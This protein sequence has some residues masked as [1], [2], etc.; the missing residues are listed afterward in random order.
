[1]KISKTMRQF[2]DYI[3]K[4]SNDPEVELF[5]MEVQV[6]TG[7]VDFK[8]QDIQAQWELWREAQLVLFSQVEI[9][10]LLKCLLQSTG[11]NDKHY[12]ELI[13]KVESLKY[14]EL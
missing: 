8:R 2:I 6:S 12:C 11:E 1:M 7:Q 4:L 9:E 5:A 13:A 14:G 3:D 10:M